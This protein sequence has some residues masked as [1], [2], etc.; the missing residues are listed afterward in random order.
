MTPWRWYRNAAGSGAAPGPC[1]IWPDVQIALEQVALTATF[2]TGRNFEAKMRAESAAWA[3]LVKGLN[4][5]AD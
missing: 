2:D 3:N 4:I 5:Q 1:R